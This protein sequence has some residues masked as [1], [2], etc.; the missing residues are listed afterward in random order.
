MCTLCV[1]SLPKDTLKIEERKQGDCILKIES[2]VVTQDHLLF[3]LAFTV[4][5]VEKE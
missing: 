3:T 5:D 4:G 2:W 1:A